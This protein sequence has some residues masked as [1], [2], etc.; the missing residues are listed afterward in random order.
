MDLVD[1]G[2]RNVLLDSAHLITDLSESLESGDE[3]GVRKLARLITNNMKTV[4]IM[5]TAE[6]GH[7]WKDVRLHLTD[8]ING[9]PI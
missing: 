1:K 2:M 6:H 8:L 3:D 5:L 4:N 7:K 9:R